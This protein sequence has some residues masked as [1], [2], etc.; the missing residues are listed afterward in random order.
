MWKPRKSKFYERLRAFLAVYLIQGTFRA[1]C[2]NF[3]AFRLATEEVLLLRSAAA[4]DT[5]EI[6]S[7]T[8]EILKLQKVARNT[9]SS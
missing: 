1:L 4:A 9:I 2:S 3:R 5:W 8:L 7:G 6:D